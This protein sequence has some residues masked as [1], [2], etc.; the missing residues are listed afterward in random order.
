MQWDHQ[1][2]QDPPSEKK[3]KEKD[4]E[5]KYDQ[6]PYEEFENAIKKYGYL[7]RVAQKH[8]DEV[9]LTKKCLKQDDL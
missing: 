3:L 9:K 6:V 8:F 2:F 5:M 1:K 7:G 4:S